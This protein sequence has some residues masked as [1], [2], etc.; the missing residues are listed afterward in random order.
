M[1]FDPT[2]NAE[3]NSETRDAARVLVN[4]A[5]EGEG[6][7]VKPEEEY[8]LT[9]I[10]T[11]RLVDQALV[12]LQIDALSY[13][14]PGDEVEVTY[15]VGPLM[16]ALM[17]AIIGVGSTAD[18]I[19]ETDDVPP[20][21]A[22]YA[23][24]AF[25]GSMIGLV[26][27][28]ILAEV[29]EFKIGTKIENSGETWP[30]KIR[31][32]IKYGNE[33]EPLQETDVVF[34]G[35]CTSS[36]ARDIKLYLPPNPNGRTRIIKAYKISRE[37]DLVKEGEQ[38]MRYKEEASF[39]SVTE[40]S[41]VK[42]SYPNSV[43][44][45]TRV[46]AKDMPNMP[47]RNYNLLLKK[48]KVPIN[49][50]T[51]SK[52]YGEMWDGRF[53]PELQWTDNPAWCLYDLISN[54]SYGLGKYGMDI[55]FID[56]W[57]FYRAAK[58]CDELIPTGY[59]PI[60]SKKTFYTNGSDV[61]NI[62]GQYESDNDFFLEFDHPGKKVAIFYQLLNGEKKYLSNTIKSVETSSRGKLKRYKIRLDKPI[63]FGIEEGQVCAEIYYPILESRYKFNALLTSPQNAFK[64]INEIAAMFRAYT[65]WG[66]GKINF[67]LD[68]PKEPLLLFGNN[69]VTEEGF[70]Y[71]STP[72]H[73]RTNAIKIKYLDESNA[74]KPKIEYVEDR[75]KI[76]DNGLYENSL[77]SLGTTTRTQAHRIAEYNVQGKNLETE[78]ISF[79][80]SMPGS[81][82]RPGDIIDVLDNKKTV[83]R[84]AGKILNFN[85]SGDG[86]VAYLDI[87]WPVRTLIDC[88]LYTSD[89]ADE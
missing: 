36:Y 55:D 29:A 22:K 26:I 62:D 6:L 32:R 67:Y 82:L 61:L 57:T 75:D 89:A 33:G 27:G 53:N 30:N 84:F 78:L 9:H 14:Y 64:M 12:T 10:I 23:A 41:S 7:N 81:Y 45:G 74:F 5:G 72:R 66:A 83:G 28:V 2:G 34:F 46:N 76:I 4:I 48:V 18:M 17:G 56:K 79:K 15:R 42:C 70:S 35:V 80:T 63:G 85:V 52:T 37:R 58:Y 86:K 73:Q 77:N 3:D 20:D 38:A 60:Y 43:V 16:M 51:E 24:A 87:D 44:I 69:N 47:K 40:I 1:I 54:N 8:P 71:S 59:S 11:N 49:Y 19:A 88:L 25:W 50:D 31:F 13:L 68:E 65:Y 39:A 21:V